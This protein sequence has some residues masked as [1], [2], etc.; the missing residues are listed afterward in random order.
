MGGAEQEGGAGDAG[1]ERLSCLI[2]SAW[3]SST[4]ELLRASLRLSSGSGLRLAMRA[5]AMELAS[6]GWWDA[7]PRWT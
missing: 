3:E 5:W 2:L 1:S 4:A 6:I 7:D